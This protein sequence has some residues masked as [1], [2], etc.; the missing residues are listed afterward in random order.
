MDP[1]TYL[2]IAENSD[3]DCRRKPHYKNDSDVS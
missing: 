3:N 2:P 1:V